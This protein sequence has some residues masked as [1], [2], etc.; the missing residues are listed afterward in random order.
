MNAR[1]RALTHCPSS[2]CQELEYFERRLSHAA[3]TE[4][5]NI[6]DFRGAPLRQWLNSLLDASWQRITY[7]TAIDLINQH[8]D[9]STDFIPLKWGDS[10]STEH[11]RFLSEK[12]FKCGLFVTHYPQSQKPFYMKPDPI[13][14]LSTPQPV[15][16]NFDLLLPGIGE[17]A[18]G[19][20]RVDDYN[21]IKLVSHVVCLMTSHPFISESESVL[22]VLARITNGTRI[23]EGPFFHTLLH[24]HRLRSGTVALPMRDL[25]SVSSVCYV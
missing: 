13:V 15:V 24:S 19:S 7:T 21:T 10:L 18:G 4:G 22:Q 5:A 8:F 6:E 3:K 9:K 11:E 1:S 25:D 20:E 23:C 17:L 12:L 2:R 14:S 16:A